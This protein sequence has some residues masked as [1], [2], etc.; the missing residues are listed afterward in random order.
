METGMMVEKKEKP[1]VPGKKM[2]MEE[3]IADHNLEDGAVEKKEKPR[4]PGKKMMV[5]KNKKPRVRGKKMLARLSRIFM[6]KKTSYTVSEEESL[7]R[8]Q[9]N[10]RE[11]FFQ[12]PEK[13]LQ[14]R[15][16]TVAGSSIQPT[17]EQKVRP[18]VFIV[19]QLR[20]S[21]VYSAAIFKLEMG[22]TLV[23]SEG[24]F[25]VFNRRKYLGKETSPRLGSVS[26]AMV[27]N[28]LY[29]ACSYSQLD[30]Q[31]GQVRQA[32][33]HVFNTLHDRLIEL[34][35]SSH[36]FV[37]PKPFP[38][39][40]AVGTL[41]LY[42]YG[43]SM[44]TSLNV[45][46][47]ALESFNIGEFEW[48]SQLPPQFNLPSCTFVNGY[49]VVKNFLLI[50]VADFNGRGSRNEFFYW[51]FSGGSNS[52]NKWEKMILSNGQKNIRYPF[53]GKA[54]FVEDVI[55][56]YNRGLY[57]YRVDCCSD[58]EGL[59]I[60]PPQLVGFPKFAAPP[61]DWSDSI[62]FSFSCAYMGIGKRFCIIRT[63]DSGCIGDQQ[64][65]AVSVVEVSG[66]M[67]CL[68]TLSST[69]CALD[70]S[71]LGSDLILDSCF[72]KGRDW[73]QDPFEL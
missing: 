28:E 15:L 44:A 31:G 12:Y 35:S 43:Q 13:G 61:V 71:G 9:E 29:L 47:P 2:M 33:V 16:K 70:I 39:V 40:M 18:V 65:V 10:L 27:G 60:S 3:R 64:F 55:Y 49:A 69:I 38:V 7:P 34:P 19:C 11:V 45:P 30:L 21:S 8:Q 67:Q 68:T 52:K 17:C 72:V 66:D 37:T 59:Q 48:E 62:H 53:S 63:G 57:A 5:L 6:D 24:R 4:V 42:V 23:K 51:N 46:A 20:N 14:R 1:L 58:K 25:E 22:K 54:E 50:S 36:G 32:P 73:E 56:S 26:C 41:Q